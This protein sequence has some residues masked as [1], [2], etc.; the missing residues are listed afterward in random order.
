M[1]EQPDNVRTC[2][3]CGYI[4]D[5]IPS[6]RCPECGTPVD[7]PAPPAVSFVVLP[8]LTFL[9][10]A[11]FLIALEQSRVVMMTAG[12]TCGA[13][14]L[15]WVIIG[16]CRRGNGFTKLESYAFAAAGIISICFFCGLSPQSTCH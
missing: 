11:T 2:A 5:Y 12:F 10:V 8:I 6:P 9:N 1:C 16:L 7:S 14:L 3:S 15:A 13:L 4:T